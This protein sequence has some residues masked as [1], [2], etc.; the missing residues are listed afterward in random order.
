MH[1]IYVIQNTVTLKLYVGLTSN[2][3]RRWINHR[4]NAR[5]GTRKSKLCD[6]MRSYGEEKFTFKVIEQHD[7]PEECSLAEI[8]WIDFFRSWDSAYGYNM[9][10]GG[11]LGIPTAETRKKMSDAKKNKPPHN[12]GKKCSEEALANIRAGH[13]KRGEEWRQSIRESNKAR[14]DEWR[15][16]VGRSPKTAEWKLKISQSLKAAHERKIR[17]LAEKEEPQIP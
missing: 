16:N 5:K 17:L 4:S 12:K 10:F 1:Y 14:S 11:S 15:Q 13:K 2:P 9:N 3:H 8:F 6:A 7:S